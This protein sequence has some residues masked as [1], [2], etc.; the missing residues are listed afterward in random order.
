MQNGERKKGIIYC[1]VSSLEQVDGTSLESQERLC[2]EYAAREEIAVS[3]VFIERGESA[4]TADRTEFVKAIA[5]CA[6]KKNRINYFI[7]YKIDR[8]SR[9]QTD[10]AIIK[11]K[12]KKYGT[13]IRSVSEKIDDTP[14]GKL[15]EIMLSGFA[16]FDNNVRTERSV[17]GMRE[18]IKKGIWVWPAPLGYYRIAQGANLTPD[19]KF[20][21][22]IGLAF[23]EY[24]KGV[25][26]F[27]SLA[28][29][30]NKRGFVT[31]QGYSAS[32]QLI[33]KIIKN[34][35]YCGIIR[36]WDIDTKGAFDPIIDENLFY[37]CQGS[38]RKHKNT[39]HV[40]KNPNFSLRKLAVCA[41]CKHRLTGS[42]S[43]GRRGTRYPYYHHHKQNCDYAKSIPK[44]SFEQLFVEYLHEITPSWEYK[45][46]FKKI[47]IDIWK[48]DYK[49]FHELNE[50]L[51]SEMSELEVRK[52]RIYEL[53]ESG[54]YSK[55]EFAAQRDMVN[56]KIAQKHALM[57]DTRIE[58]FNMDEALEYCFNFILKTAESWLEME[59]KPERRLWFQNCIFEDGEILF[60]G[61]KFGTAKLSPIYSMYREYLHD[62]ST[63]VTLCLKNWNQIFL[64]IKNFRHNFDKQEADLELI[65]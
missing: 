3:G 50:K 42:Y 41:F 11:Q 6:D 22:Y 12:L 62:P 40:I 4:K 26:T 31:R 56:R 21:P 15:M 29:F 57:A 20:A 54:T 47:V 5:F 13:E 14:S 48:S 46:V 23:E 33:E 9:N 59:N 64:Y 65:A 63:L 16:E 61:N 7:V 39:P 55:E 19:P 51:R 17:N 53:F 25:H 37:L 38:G 52:Q 28:K 24:A 58:E 8:F 2:N 27:D 60:Y 36:V 30:L 43:R 1:R 34:P 18:R 44:E 32:P 10:Y 49:K 35:I 45:E